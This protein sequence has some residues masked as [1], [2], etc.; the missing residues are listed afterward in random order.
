MIG[1]V[2]KAVY[3]PANFSGC[4]QSQTE[5][6]VHYRKQIIPKIVIGFYNPTSAQHVI[7]PCLVSSPIIIQQKCKQLIPFAEKW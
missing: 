3:A 4:S 1:K 6:V 7:T 5:T 2:I